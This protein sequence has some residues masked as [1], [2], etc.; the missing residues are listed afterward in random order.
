MAIDPVSHMAVEQATAVAAQLMGKTYYCCSHGCE[1]EL[2]SGADEF[3]V[4]LSLCDR[5]T[6]A[7]SAEAKRTLSRPGDRPTTAERKR[8]TA[9]T[10]VEG[11]HEDDRGRTCG[12]GARA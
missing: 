3:P 4:S 7:S 5:R 8:V 12:I 1:A 10:V 11:I 9:G 6:R 2:L